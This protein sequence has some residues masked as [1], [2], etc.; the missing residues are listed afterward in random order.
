MGDDKDKDKKK[1][2]SYIIYL[3]DT[4][5]FASP[6]D[7]NMSVDSGYDQ[8]HCFSNVEPED[9]KNLV[10]DAIFSRGVKGCKYTALF[11]GGSDLPKVLQVLEE[12]KKAM[13]PPFEVPIMI[14]PRGAYT[15][16]A[17]A[18]AKTE[19]VLMEMGGFE[20]KNVTI[21]AGTGPVGQVAAILSA[22]S[23]GNPLI[24]SR[25]FDRAKSIAER[26]SQEYQINVRYAQGANPE[27][28]YEASKDADAIIAAGKAG[29]QLIS[30]ATLERLDRCKV[31]ADINAVPPLGV[32]GLGSLDDKQEFMPG[33]VGIGALAIG[34]LKLKSEKK[35]LKNIKG[36]TGVF[37]FEEA[38]DISKELLAKKKKKMQ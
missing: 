2:K 35:A 18:V 36:T 8:V 11:I 24:T 31:A 27:E 23:G 21:L 34:D 4:D 32:E 14:D 5:K 38:Y 22:K 19:E 20:G 13:V 25:K 9:V 6:F 29:Y 30:K 16:A 15:T 3:I 12:A 1:E 37:S 17:A 26:L 28:I 33:K 7:I 10:Q